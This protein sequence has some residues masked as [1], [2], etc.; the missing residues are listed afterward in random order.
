MMS[1]RIAVDLWRTRTNAIPETLALKAQ[2]DLLASAGR[3]PLTLAT[4][5]R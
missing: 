4:T 3:R 2:V 5:E 1:S